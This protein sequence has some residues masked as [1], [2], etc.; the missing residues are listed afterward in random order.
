MYR[1][2]RGKAG[3]LVRDYSFGGG[4]VGFPNGPPSAPWGNGGAKALSYQHEVGQMTKV[5]RSPFRMHSSVST[6]R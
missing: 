4:R 2:D 5:Q 6:D 1:L 3:R